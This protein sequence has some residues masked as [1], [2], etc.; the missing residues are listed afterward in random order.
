[1]VV[2]GSVLL[3]LVLLAG[4]LILLEAGFR[5]GRRFTGARGGEGTNI[6]DSAVFALLG[7]LLGF[8]FAGSVERLN[9]RRDLIVQEANAIGTAYLRVDLLAPEDQPAIRS[10][11]RNYIA[12]RIE[13]YR[14]I[15]SDKDASLVAA[16]ADQLQSEMW[17]SAVASVSRSPLADAGE[18]V[19]PAINDMIDITTE[20]KVALDTHIPGLV[21]VLL[22]GVSLFSALLAGIGVSRHGLRQP[23]HGGVFAIAV[24]LTIYTIMDLDSPRSGFIRLDAADKVMVQLQQSMGAASPTPVL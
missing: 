16:R 1:M 21:V 14:E 20:R 19:L 7:L 13:I 2:F 24:S 11:F 15:D 9:L 5:L 3:C 10:A 8:A 12:E 17:R 4:M 6:F 18:V 22:F 23:L